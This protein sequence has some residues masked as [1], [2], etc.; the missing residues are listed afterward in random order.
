MCSLKHP[1]T[2]HITN[3]EANAY[4]EKTITSALVE[5]ENGWNDIGAGASE[6]IMPVVPVKKK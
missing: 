4:K 2:L 3:R 5:I 1:T 6:F